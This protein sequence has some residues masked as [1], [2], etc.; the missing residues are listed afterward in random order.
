MTRLN[1]SDRTQL[2]NQIYTKDGKLHLV[3]TPKNSATEV[4]VEVK[5]I[6]P[7]DKA[8]KKISM[9]MAL[10]R[11]D[12]HSDGAGYLIT[13]NTRGRENRVW[14]GP[15]WNASPTLG[16]YICE[17]ENEKVLCREKEG[18]ELYQYAL[19]EGVEYSVEA[20]MDESVDQGRDLNFTVIEHSGVENSSAN[21]PSG[22]PIKNFKFYLFS[23]PG[24]DFHMTVDDILITYAE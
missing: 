22:G 4:N 11:Q 8:I 1:E 23:D 2:P 13:S 14:M 15:N 3:V 19:D 6:L 9:K 5:S 18:A 7:R 17:D 20:V 21:A 24:R 12:G 10:V 16:Y